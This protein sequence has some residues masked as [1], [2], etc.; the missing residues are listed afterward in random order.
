MCSA[1][2]KLAVVCLTAARCA[3]CKVLVW[4]DP[5]GA[6]VAVGTEQTTTSTA[7]LEIPVGVGLGIEI[8]ED[9]DEAFTDDEYDGND[10]E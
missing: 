10:D 1:P 8:V 4:V 6:G 9:D 5:G 7:I 3:C 2:T